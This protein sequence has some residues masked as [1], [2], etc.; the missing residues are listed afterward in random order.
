MTIQSQLNDLD[1]LGLLCFDRC[2][3]GT[4]VELDVDGK[5]EVIF[6]LANHN[7]RSTKLRSILKTLADDVG[8]IAKYAECFDLRFFVSTFAGYG[9]HSACMLTLNQF[10]KLLCAQKANDGGDQ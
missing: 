6:I 10:Q 7:P 1:E 9:L 8:K 4:G 3:S 5:P 2:K